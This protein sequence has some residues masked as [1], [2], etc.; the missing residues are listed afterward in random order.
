MVLL[1]SN[2]QW[3]S[4]DVPLLTKWRFRNDYVDHL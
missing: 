4:V 1:R 3:W 2:A